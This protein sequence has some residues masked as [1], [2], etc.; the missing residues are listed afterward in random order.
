MTAI[1]DPDRKSYSLFIRLI[2]RFHS[3]DW[4]FDGLDVSIRTESVLEVAGRNGDPME[5]FELA[6]MQIEKIVTG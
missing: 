5:E 6:P 4:S 1:E 3:D 2:L